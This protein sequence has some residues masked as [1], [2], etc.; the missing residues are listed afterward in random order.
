MKTTHTIA[1]SLALMLA[2]ACG[3]SEPAKTAYE[4]PPSPPAVGFPPQG[5][6]HP[7]PE[8]MTEPPASVNTPPGPTSADVPREG[9]RAGNAEAQP[10]IP[11]TDGQIL[12]ITHTANIGEIDQARLA[13]SRSKDARVRS[14][15]QMMVQDHSQADK[16]GMVLAKKENLERA[17]SAASESLESDTQSTTGT[18]KANPAAD[19]DKSYVD[20]QI[21]E[22]QAVLDTIDQKLVVNA[23]N[24][25]LKAYLTEIRAAV[26]SH[27][28]HAQDVQS[29]LQN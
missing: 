10:A 26:A 28:K 22:H 16:K 25:D 27:L 1:S 21:R 20:A 14:L 8:A 11:L 5:S 18:L 6:V 13:L 4:A 19:F 29:E 3:N 23:T 24:P 17:P 15:A 7:S 2:A 12:Q 9:P